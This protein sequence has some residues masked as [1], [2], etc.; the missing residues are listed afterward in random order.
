V[1]VFAG[2]GLRR[3]GSAALDVDRLR[4][5]LDGATAGDRAAAE[6]VVTALA[7]VIASL[8][9]ILDPQAVVV[10]GPW[11]DHPILADRLT[12]AVHE[13]AAVPT[14]IRFAELGPDAP[15]RGARRSAVGAAQQAL[16]GQVVTREA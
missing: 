12:A 5:V 7:G 16:T 14:E 3:P 6:V 2:L 1:E 9:T 11:A 4:T 15:H 8:A 10:G 13:L